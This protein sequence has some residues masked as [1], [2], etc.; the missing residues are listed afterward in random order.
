MKLICA[1]CKKILREGSEPTSHGI[2][3]E[4]RAKCFP[5]SLQ[6]AEKNGIGPAT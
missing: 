2:C 6:F 4:C 1:W 5:D 3:P